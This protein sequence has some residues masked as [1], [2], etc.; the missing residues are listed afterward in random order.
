MTSTFSNK[1]IYKSIVNYARAKFIKTYGGLL[2]SGQTSSNCN[3]DL[4]IRE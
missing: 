4:L 3:H 1:F 2:R